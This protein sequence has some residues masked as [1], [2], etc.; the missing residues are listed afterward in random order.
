MTRS[1]LKKRVKCDTMKPR[2]ERVDLSR[3]CGCR[4]A[5][6]A[7]LRCKAMGINKYYEN[8]IFSGGTKI[9]VSRQV[10]VNY[11]DTAHWHP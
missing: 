3:R 7:A 9:N 1:G 11:F 6:R 2:D 10:N 4:F 8:L 5:L